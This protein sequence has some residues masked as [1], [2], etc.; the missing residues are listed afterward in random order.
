MSA[1]APTPTSAEPDASPVLLAPRPPAGRSRTLRSVTAAGWG[2]A[3]AAAVAVLVGSLTGWREWLGF[4]I[5]GA[6]VCLLAVLLSLGGFAYEMS[7]RLSDRRLVVGEH[8]QIAVRIRNTSRRRLLPAE[9][10]LAVTDRTYAVTLPGLPALG[11]HDV[12]LPVP[13]DRRAVLTLGPIAAVRSDPVGL[14]RRV[15]SW[16][17]GERVYVVPR[18]VHTAGALAGFVR[19]LEGEESTQRTAADLSFHS[20]RAYVPGDDRRHISW[21]KTAVAGGLLVRE[22][23]ETRRSVVVLALSTDLADYAADDPE[24][25]FELAV[26]IAASITTDLVR[27][28]RAVTTCTAGPDGADVR[29]FGVPTVLEQFAA[30]RTATDGGALTDAVRAGVRRHPDL[31][32]LIPVFGSRVDAATV[33][34]AYRLRPEG[35]TVLGLRAELGARGLGWFAPDTVTVP[36]LDLLP[37]LLREASR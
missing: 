9:L 18:T 22:F 12:L 21:K 16:P 37:K 30:L 4:G 15:V 5:A 1:P 2:L 6:V 29:G 25:E 28:G 11:V 13:T 33:H 17:F 8:G 7:M 26:S 14:V 32:L 34:A 27:A 35:S 3:G 31:S 19:D 23:L 20:L 10:E 36:V 24:E